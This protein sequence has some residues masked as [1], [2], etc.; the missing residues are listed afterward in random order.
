MK[1]TTIILLAFLLL[2]PVTAFGETERY[3]AGVSL[4]DFCL[5]ETMERGATFPISV[6]APDPDIETLTVDLLCDPEVFVYDYF[7]SYDTVYPFEQN[8]KKTDYGYRIDVTRT[9]FEAVPGMTLIGDRF[10]FRCVSETDSTL[11]GIRGTVTMRGQAPREAKLRYTLPSARVLRREQLPTLKIGAH[12]RGEY[13]LLTRET[14]VPAA[15]AMAK[16]TLLA[17]TAVY[18]EILVMRGDRRPADDQLVRQGDR[19]VTVLDGRVVSEREL[20]VFGDANGDGAITA[21]DARLVLR[22]SAKLAE[23]SYPAKLAVDL[24]SDGRL[25][26]K[27]ARTIL[28]VSAKLESFT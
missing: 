28:R 18:D 4:P 11:T 13:E 1:K 26:A 9:G 19:L 3:D 22:A 21:G 12:Y 23:I 8:I 2:L 17:D 10:E 15:I 20:L 27:E 7:L 16:D 24:D 25:T 14:E 5:Y 6:V